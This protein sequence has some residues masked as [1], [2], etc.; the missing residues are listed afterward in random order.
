MSERWFQVSK[1]ILDQIEKLEKMEKKDRLEHVKSMRFVLSALQRSLLGWTQWVSNPDVM[2]RFT[3]EELE[4]MD[5][6]LA[7]FARSFIEYD[8]QITKK[9]EEKGLEAQRRVERREREGGGV[10]IF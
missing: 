10:Y 8:M 9:G 1:R 6:K 4:E 7:D 2:T 5:R 3:R